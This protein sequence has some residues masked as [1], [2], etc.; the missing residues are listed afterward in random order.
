MTGK[1]FKEFAALVPDHAVVEMD[2]GYSSANWK[3]LGVAKIRARLI[4]TPN[5][6]ESADESTLRNL[7]TVNG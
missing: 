6:E 1:Q 7:Q 4:V 5:V 2:E 3:P